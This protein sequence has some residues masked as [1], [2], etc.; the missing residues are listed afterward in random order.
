MDDHNKEHAQAVDGTKGLKYLTENDT[1]TER[2]KLPA[3]EIIEKFQ[4]I[5]EETF[6]HKT[7][8][9]FQNSRPG[10]HNER[11]KS[12][13]LDA[14]KQ[15]F[16]SGNTAGN[17]TVSPSG[18][19]LPSLFHPLTPLP[20]KQGSR[21]SLDKRTEKASPRLSHRRH[22]VSHVV[23]E[24]SKHDLQ[25]LSHLHEIKLMELNTIVKPEDKKPRTR[26]ETDTEKD[27]PKWLS[28]EDIHAFYNMW[29]KPEKFKVKPGMKTRKDLQLTNAVEGVPE[30]GD[31]EQ[32]GR[33]R[34]F[35]F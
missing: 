12:F 8:S 35:S 15:P 20:T 9:S 5:K 2:V 29:E 21:E 30:E 1:K 22:S 3:S 28:G 6:K 10:N 26:T 19:P 16:A 11:K 31:T 14:E 13:S 4:K 27:P 24:Y 33:P 32:Y 34:V 18:M 25:T 17:G 7:K 23:T